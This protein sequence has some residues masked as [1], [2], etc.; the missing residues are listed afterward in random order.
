MHTYGKK[1]HPLTIRHKLQIIELVI[2]RNGNLS[3]LNIKKTNYK[4]LP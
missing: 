2:N 3:L 4:E 1:V